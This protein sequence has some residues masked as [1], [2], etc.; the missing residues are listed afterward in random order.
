MTQTST[1]PA[2][3][4]EI[5]RSIRRRTF[6]ALL[7]VFQVASCASSV[8][9]TVLNSDRIRQTFGS[10][11]VEILYSS[12]RRRIS[13]LYS[14]VPGSEIT[15]TFAV[16]DFN[17]PMS[18]ELTREHERIVAGGSIG[19]TFRRAGW[20]IEK[21]HIFIGELNVTNQHSAIAELMQIAL[22]RQLAVHVYVFAVT[23]DEQAFNYATIYE[24]HH[25]EYMNPD[26]LQMLYG[27]M[28]FD[29]SGR[30]DLDDFIT[31]PEEFMDS[32]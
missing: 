16:V 3:A 12:Q 14:G 21:R 22:P 1:H 8:D 7:L 6:A 25:P 10:Y 31:L 23:R 9:D 13:S 5:H 20:A 27:E 18:P 32:N 11:D 4:G 17:L 19:A 2:A 26:D 24:I 30:S 28:L 29:D 15:R